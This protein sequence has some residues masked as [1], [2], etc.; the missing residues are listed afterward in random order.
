MFPENFNGLSLTRIISGLSKSLNIAQQIIPI[1]EKS[2]PM[3]TN[4]KKTFGILKEIN[5]SELVKKSSYLKKN[6]PL[7]TNNNF[8]KKATFKKNNSFSNPVFFK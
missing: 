8:I 4:A 3:I 2:K 6:T 5:I 1:Y 7:K